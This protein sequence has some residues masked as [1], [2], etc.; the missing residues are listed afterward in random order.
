MK[1]YLHETPGRLRIKI[2]GLK[3]KTQAV[4]SVRE[5]LLELAGVEEV[6]ANAFTGSIVVIHDRDAIGAQDVLDLLDE[7][8][9][10]D[11]SH[12]APTA[13]YHERAFSKAGAA[14]GKAVFGMAVERALAP[15]GL[16]FLAALL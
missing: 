15:R 16:S 6:T 4:E 8:G 14:V 9:H 11:A 12:G 7:L 5:E 10:I 2:P 13:V 3:G 1:Y